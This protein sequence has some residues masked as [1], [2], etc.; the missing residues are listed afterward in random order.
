MTPMRGRS[1]S[2]SAIGSSPSTRTDAG[3]GDDEP[4][5]HLDR[6]GLAGA[7]GAE[8]GEHLG[9]LDV[10]VDTVDGGECRRSV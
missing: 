10:E 7:V 5:A 9:A 3:V 2:E 8:Q 4:F 6:G 1:R